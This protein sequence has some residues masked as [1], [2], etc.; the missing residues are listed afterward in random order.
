[1]C[2]PTPSG[3]GDAVTSLALTADGDV[4]AETI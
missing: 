3:T 1:M 4:L 2:R